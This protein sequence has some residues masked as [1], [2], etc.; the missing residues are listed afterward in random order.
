MLPSLI[1]SYIGLQS[2]RQEQIRQEEAF[3]QN[4]GHSLDVAVS[5]IGSEVEDRL[6]AIMNSMP[7]FGAMPG[8]SFIRQIRSVVAHAPLIDEA[9][10]LDRD[11]DVHYPRNFLDGRD[12]RQPLAYHDQ[13]FF[14]Q[15]VAFEARDMP[16]EAI[17]HYRMGL[18]ASGC[19]TQTLAL[20]NAIA[21]C[22][23]KMDQLTEA[24]VYFREIIHVDGGRF[25]GGE[26][27][28]VLL[29]YVQLAGIESSLNSP[30]AALNT[31]LDFY[32][33]M[34]KQFHYLQPAQYGFYV[35][36]IKGR[37]ERKMPGASGAQSERY[38]LIREMEEAAGAE[39]SFRLFFDRH[40]L[41]VCRNFIQ[42]SGERAGLNY[43]R[44]KTDEER[45]IIALQMT[46]GASGYQ[47]IRGIVLNAGEMNRALRI[48]VESHNVR[49]Q[50]EVILLPPADRDKD[51]SGA[52]EEPQ[53]ISTGLGNIQALF[54]GYALGIDL[55]ENA[56][57]E[58]IHRTTLMLYYSLFAAIVGVIFFGLVFIFRDIYRERQVQQL[59]SS[60]IA[61][62]SHEIKTP[63]STI[64]VLAGNLAEG[65]IN[66]EEKQKSYFRMI[67]REAEKLSYLAEN[68][69]DFSSMEA[70][71]KVYRKQMIS[72][73]DLLR[74]VLRRFYMMHQKESIT[75]HDAIP[76][77]L[78]DVLASPEG[79]EQAV[80]N[81]LDN[82]VRHSGENKGIW[83]RLIQNKTGAVISVTDKGVGIA[84]GEQQKIFEKFYRVENKGQNSPGSGIGLSLVREIAHMH[85]GS[86]EVKSEPG[87]GSEFSLIIPLHHGKDIADR[88]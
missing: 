49:E 41:P 38:R 7:V 79:I 29:A 18:Q 52:G 17:L 80:L 44:L 31:M 34:V 48:A 13:P 64:R 25:L 74:K 46:E 23:L 58:N 19:D 10:L 77:G 47:G 1:I 2:I 60:F 86:I 28:F 40:V 50:F 61:N 22:R 20:M 45:L 14:D 78:P 55:G 84:P 6:H 83:L 16:E 5:R 69:L 87:K 72:L 59:K 24:G 75:V 27:P 66:R 32:E 9:F 62:V 82:A 81:L 65:L 4:L 21:R 73:H 12:A 37:I 26:V 71:R 51:A 67:N 68:I 8:S 43:V 54:P 76:Q 39:R 15:G 63:I 30:S 85:N 88:G 33:I 42:L 53:M 57:F 56:A 70:K 11:F 35:A 3:I 36:G